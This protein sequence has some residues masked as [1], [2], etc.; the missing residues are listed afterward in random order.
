MATCDSLPGACCLVDQCQILSEEVCTGIDGVF[1]G[2]NTACSSGAC[3]NATP[4]VP[5]P[6][7]NFPQ[8]G[9]QDVEPDGYAGNAVDV[10]E[11]VLLIGA[12]GEELNGLS[13]AG[14]AYIF[15]LTISGQE[16]RD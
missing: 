14:S 7:Y 8:N 3:L 6:P 9:P 15:N 4:Y 16:L 12:M 10:E 5:F 11:R 13:N 2:P 1:L